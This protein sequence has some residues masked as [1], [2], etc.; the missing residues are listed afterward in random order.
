M[1]LVKG[2]TFSALLEGRRDPS[3]DLRRFLTIFEQVCQAVA[4]AHARNVVHRDL[5]PSNVLVGAFGEVQVVDWGFAKVLGREKSEEDRQGE[6]DPSI[7]TTVRTGSTGSESMPGSVMGTPAYMPPEQAL[8]KVDEVDTR[9]DAFAL[10]AILTEILTGEPPY[11]GEALEQLTK[12]AASRT[13]EALARLDACG[14]DA[15][16]VDLARRCLAPGRSDRPADAGALASEVAA[17]LAAVEERARR[18]ELLAVEERA[19]LE[20]QRRR[21][22]YERKARRRTI[23]L[24]AAILVAVL[25]GGGTAG[26]SARQK[27]ARVARADAAA[28]RAMDAASGHRGRKEWV[29]ALAM[30]R[31]ATALSNDGGLETREEARALLAAIEEEAEAA[32][33]AEEQR[34]RD[35]A[36][37]AALYRIRQQ[38]GPAQAAQAT[39][40]M[41]LDAFRD[42]GVD[43]E[44]GSPEAAAEAL[45]GSTAAEDF[46][47]ALDDWVW[48]RRRKLT[49]EW[50]TLDRVARLA[51]PDPWRVRLREASASEDL[52]ALAELAEEVRD[53]GLSPRTWQLLGTALQES[54][55]PA[56]AALVLRQARRLHP[57]DVWVQVQLAWVL[58]AVDPPEWREAA[59]CYA[60]A[61]ALRPTGA[62]SVWLHRRLGQSLLRAG[63]REAALRE[64]AHARRLAAGRG[65]D[66]WRIAEV[67]VEAKARRAAIEV[68]EESYRADPD[69][70][71]IHNEWGRACMDVRDYEVAARRFR[72]AIEEHERVGEWSPEHLA[73]PWSNLAN[74]L[75]NM[76][77][78]PEAE[79]A[80]RK[81]I[82]LKP[83]YSIA[84]AHLARARGG[85]GRRDEAFEHYE[86]AVELDPENHLAWRSLG[87]ALLRSNCLEEAASAFRSSV[88]ANP[89]YAQ[90]WLNLGNTLRSLG[91]LDGA[92]EAYRRGIDAAPSYAQNHN[93]LGNFLLWFRDD[94]EGALECFEEALRHDPE[95]HHAHNN[96]GVVLARPE[97]AMYAEAEACFRRAMALRPKLA[98]S[99]NELAWLLVS[100]ADPAFRKPERAVPLAEK[101]V[102]LNPRFQPAWNTLGVARYRTGRFEKALEALEESVRLGTG[103][104]VSDW[105][106]LAMVHAK[107]GSRDEAARWLR[108]AEAWIEEQEKVEPDVESLR[109]E[110]V[111][112]LEEGR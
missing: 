56:A 81:A 30:A 107:L 84:W 14:A 35:E 73:V 63:D 28:A 53:R 49:T 78:F 75:N 12:A 59:H 33:R 23:A 25:L 95:L 15:P 92:E 3:E 90:A 32:R 1:K 71:C 26:W 57:D 20:R 105:L 61:I 5:K 19:R 43:F 66:L 13:D 60:A 93:N 22:E 98:G 80:A 38:R 77:K 42:Y 64:L 29:R 72:T 99:F 86:K 55:D 89:G 62:G 46:A 2:K 41:Y 16:M 58:E 100:C 83:D 102:E 106:F 9:S 70:P 88:A 52:A 101:A 54:G 109:G 36:L 76:R 50:E 34:R 91:D 85:Q 44:T 18:A 7:V 31:E 74:A 4:Y 82:E 67:L 24:A 87:I 39:D 51:D 103:G 68:F 40:A 48:L 96:R 97:F 104:D 108:K 21:A 79:A 8:G 11:T 27:R 37:V 17:H 65:N 6:G 111:S 110:A 112:V 45:R 94:P 47:A 69:A 10:G